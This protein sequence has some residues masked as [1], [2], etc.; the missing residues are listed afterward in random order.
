MKRW[1]RPNTTEPPPPPLGRPQYIT[2]NW[3]AFFFLTLLAVVLGILIANYVWTW[4]VAEGIKS[5]FGG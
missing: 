4:L 5:A 1:Q 2:F 3:V